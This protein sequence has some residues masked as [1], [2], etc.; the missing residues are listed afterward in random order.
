MLL[1]FGSSFSVGIAGLLLFGR[2]S[3]V[4]C[5]GSHH[6]LFLRLFHSG[7]LRSVHHL[8]SLVSTS[9]IRFYPGGMFFF[10]LVVAVLAEAHSL[11]L[12]A[13][14]TV[15]TVTIILRLGS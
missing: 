15:S 12:F 13:T 6:V 11:L 10:F 3:S 5:S 2:Y 7:S 8:R 1:W 4:G 14:T 9:S